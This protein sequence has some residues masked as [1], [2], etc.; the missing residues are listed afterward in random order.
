MKGKG[1]NM[2]YALVLQEYGKNGVFNHFVDN[3]L[4]SDYNIDDYDL[5]NFYGLTVESCGYPKS[6]DPKKLQELA[7]REFIGMGYFDS[8]F[9]ISTQHVGRYN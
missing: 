5:A 3:D 9:L 2:T 1:K 4:L 7:Q 8:Y 6:D